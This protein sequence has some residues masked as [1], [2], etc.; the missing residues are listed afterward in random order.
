[1]VGTFRAVANIPPAVVPVEK[2]L[3]EQVEKI[4]HSG[5][6][7]GSEI[8]R[9]LLE[10]LATRAIEDPAAPVKAREIAAA[11]FG[12]T[13]NFDPQSDSIVRVHCYR[14]RSKL[15]EYYLSEGSKDETVIAFR[16]GSYDLISTHRTAPMAA[17]EVTVAVEEPLEE[18]TPERAQFPW[19]RAIRF[20]PWA[21]IFVLAMAAVVWV[22]TQRANAQL[23]PAL[24]TFWSSFLDNKSRA[25]IVYSNMRVRSMDSSRILILPSNGEVL[26]VFHITRFFTSVRKAVSPK[27]SRML[28]WDE[29]KDADLIFIG[30]PLAE[31]P[32]RA[33]P[34]F[35]DFAF[36]T[37]IEDEEPFIENIRPR[38]GDPVIFRGSPSP[39][40]FDYAVVA[41]TKPFSSKNRALTLAG[42]TGYGTQ[43]AT[44]FV[45]REDRVQEL[46]SRL[47]IKPGDPMPL[48]EAVLRFNVQGEV[49]IQ[50][51]IVVV[52]RL[53]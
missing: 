34:T 19:L 1:M 29:A 38:K 39:K 33:I 13:D 52:H 8:L 48:F 9:K 24:A 51:E 20:L 36:R 11:V 12:R 44:E 40:R 30:G 2:T 15:V 10:Y 27:H 26:G 14:L 4:V 37:Q 32:L 53:N 6:F 22:S 43:G 5:A 21:G 47:S 49:A 3:G 16:K 17:A 50:P 23:T 25:L 46:L 18:P 41:L 31:T 42:M 7:R 28:A 45:T 35:H